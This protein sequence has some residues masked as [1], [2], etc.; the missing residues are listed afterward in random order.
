V[1][2]GDAYCTPARLARLPIRRVFQE[3]KYFAE[4]N[5]RGRPFLAWNG[6]LRPA[7]RRMTPEG[8]LRFRRSF[9]QMRNGPAW[10][11]RNWE[12]IASRPLPRMPDRCLSSL[13]SGYWQRAMALVEYAAARAGLELRHP[14][15]DRRIVEFVRTLPIRMI[16]RDGL[17]KWILR[18]AMHGILPEKIRV[19]RT[20][21]ITWQALHFGWQQE[22]QKI[23]GMLQ[24][25]RTCSLGWTKPALLRSAW[26]DYWNGDQAE[27]WNLNA[28]LNV[29]FWLARLEG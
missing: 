5:H 3:W 21:G 22:R 9:L 16:F 12:S 17:T 14:Y 25:S 20:N 15:M 11:S 4:K 10:A 8:L 28:W 6:L 1:L 27:T 18:R 13:H 23:E 19:R 24:E 26:S 29:E 7:F 2:D